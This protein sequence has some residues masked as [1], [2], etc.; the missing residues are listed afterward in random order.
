MSLRHYLVLIGVAALVTRLSMP[1]VIKYAWKWG[2]VDN[3]GGR[4]IH[5]H[6]V[7]RAGGIAI[8]LGMLAAVLVQMY[9]E[10]FMGWGEILLGGDAVNRELLGIFAGISVIF[11]VGLLDDFV[12]LS[13]LAKFVGQLFAAGIVVWSGTLIEF[14]G[15]PF[16]GGLIILGSLSIPVTLVYIVGFTN[17]V[18]LIDG[19]DGLAGGISTIAAGSML[20]VAAQLN[21]LDAAVLAAVLIGA[22]LAFLRFNFNPASVFMGDSG[23][24]VLGFMLAVIS[25]LGVMRST[26]TMALL[27]P[28]LIIGVPILDTGS[29]I[30]RRIRGNRPIQEADRGHIHHR[31]LNRGF[32]QR[33]TVVIVWI[34]SA[35]LAA[36]GYVI[37]NAPS[38]I[39][40]AAFAVLIILSV[41]LANW[42]GIWEVV[43]HHDAGS[44]Q[45]R[46]GGKR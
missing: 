21:R 17:V 14:V 10:Y 23:S 8:F 45:D 29:A 37:A 13:P 15:N 16:G 31:L 18:N 27:V 32:N 4:K 36:G 42:L 11:L 38:S 28:L 24:L 26:A 44:P 1:L 34:W 6:P 22:C 3:P 35:A 33:Q 43:Y 7:P 9:G 25:L 30:V 2:M 39:K 19:L 40:V 12:D 41:M 20:L 46:Q 5:T